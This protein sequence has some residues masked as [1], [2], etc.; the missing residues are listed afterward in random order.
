MLARTGPR[1]VGISVARM[2]SIDLNLR[3]TEV[4]TPKVETMDRSLDST[5]TKRS[6]SEVKPIFEEPTSDDQLLQL[7]QTFHSSIP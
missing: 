6:M 7:K 3:T 5:H 4:L 2:H 1:H